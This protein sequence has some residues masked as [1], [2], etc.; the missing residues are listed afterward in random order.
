LLNFFIITIFH[1]FKG[2]KKIWVKSICPLD[3][4]PPNFQFRHNRL[5]LQ[6]IVNVLPMTKIAF[7]FFFLNIY[8]YIKEKYIKT[9]DQIKRI[10]ENFKKFTLFFFFFK[11]IFFLFGFFF[12]FIIN[13]VL[14]F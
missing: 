2:L 5:K 6:K 10:K 4:V 3:N 12:K 11:R 9:S 7:I 13:I 14:F 8:I 1:I